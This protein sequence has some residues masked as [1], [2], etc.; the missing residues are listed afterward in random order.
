MRLRVV[1][2]VKKGWSPFTYG[3]GPSLFLLGFFDESTVFL[4]GA[5]GLEP[6]LYGF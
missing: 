4:V 5:V 1:D 3:L 2:D 6:T